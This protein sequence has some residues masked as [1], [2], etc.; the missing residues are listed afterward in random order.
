MNKEDKDI[1]KKAE[2]LMDISNHIYIWVTH[3]T[4]SNNGILLNGLAFN[5]GYGFGVDA[6]REYSGA[7]DLLLGDI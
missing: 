6:V 3:T 4:T 5:G 7:L 2:Y 1:L